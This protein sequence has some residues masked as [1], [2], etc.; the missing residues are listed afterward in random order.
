MKTLYFALIA[1]WFAASSAAAE[2]KAQ[3]GGYSM[4]PSM[5]MDSVQVIL[6]AFHDYVNSLEMIN[7]EAGAELQQAIAAIPVKGDTAITPAQEADLHAWLYDFLVAFSVS[8]S[9]SLA[10][11]FYLRE[12]VN[13]PEGIEKL[14]NQLASEGLLKGE[15]PF[16]ILKAGHRQLLDKNEYD[17][18]FGKVSFFA[19]AF[20]V[21]ER[22]AEYSSYIESL[23][24]SGMI[25]PAA[26]SSNPSK[27]KSE[28][29]ERLQA[30]KPQTFVEVM[31]IGE[32]PEEFASFEGVARTPFFFRMAWDPDKAMWRHVEIVYCLGTPYFLFSDL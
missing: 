23:I 14:K 1:A 27:M 29:Q 11:A 20:E 4:H 8:S 21:S 7:V 30:G 25:P 32:G 22:Q 13:N 12:G 2:P 31:F 17:Y 19:R 5:T 24:G 15:T 26:V 3:Y 10:A 18:Y 16:D 28:V 6:Q 9:D